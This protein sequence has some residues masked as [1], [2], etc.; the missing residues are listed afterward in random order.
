[1]R[2]TLNIPSLPSA[3]QTSAPR[4][5]AGY[6]ADDHGFKLTASLRLPTVTDDGQVQRLMLAY[7]RDARRNRVHELTLPQ[8]YTAV[9]V[10]DSL[11]WTSQV[12]GYVNDKVFEVTV[13][14][15]SLR[16][17]LPRFGLRER[18]GADY[19]YDPSD[20]LP[21]STGSVTTPEPPPRA[22]PILPFRE[23][24]FLMGPVRLAARASR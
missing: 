19:V 16:L 6:L 10:L 5:D 12:N 7:L 18:D 1:M 3:G 14:G 4:H 9:D 2:C 13:R 21:T 24:L 11:G 17:L 8:N 22:R 20:R 15:D 23:F